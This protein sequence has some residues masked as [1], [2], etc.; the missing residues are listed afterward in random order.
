M[1]AP[2][3]YPVTVSPTTERQLLA[4]VAALLHAREVP[5]LIG[6]HGD[7]IGLP[8]GVYEVLKAVVS[9]MQEGKAVAVIPQDTVMTTQDAAD[10]LAV[11]RPT[12][13]KFLEAGRIPF[14]QPGRHRRVKLADLIAFQEQQCHERRAALDEITRNATAEPTATEFVTT[15]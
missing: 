2:A 7:R 3:A 10:F 6:P 8:A 15:R 1:T 9:A 14:T 11:S 12:L 5:A 13:V 4:E